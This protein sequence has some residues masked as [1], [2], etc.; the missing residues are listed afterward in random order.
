MPRPTVKIKLE[1][2]KCSKSFEVLKWEFSNKEKR[3][4]K[5]YYCSADC[6]NEA[7]KMGGE[8]STSWKGGRRIFPSRGGY[9]MVT[10][11]P[12]KRVLEHRLVMEKHLNRK[13]DVKEVVHHINGNPSDN[14]VENLVVCKSAGYHTE[15]YHPKKRNKQ[16]KYA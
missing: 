16:G 7:Q 3:G 8:F 4:T 14:R 6:K 10:I 11:A 2:F 12:R 13:L 1:C 9:V 5:K 15:T